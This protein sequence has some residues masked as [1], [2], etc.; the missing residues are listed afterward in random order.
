MAEKK[1][2]VK[3]K[4]RWGKEIIEVPDGINRTLKKEINKVL[5]SFFDGEGMEK[6]KDRWGKTDYPIWKFFGNIKFA[7]N[8]YTI[9]KLVLPTLISFFKEK[10]Y[11]VSDLEGISLEEDDCPEVTVE[12]VKLNKYKQQQLYIKVPLRPGM[13]FK[14]SFSEVWCDGVWYGGSTE[15]QAILKVNLDKIKDTFQ[16]LEE[17]DMFALEKFEEYL[18]EHADELVD[19]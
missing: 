15:G 17:L 1:I 18:E 6:E 19:E 12:G 11:D 5:R 16:I 9:D 13:S 14:E 10:E 3:G 7:K 2:T 8:Q 4:D